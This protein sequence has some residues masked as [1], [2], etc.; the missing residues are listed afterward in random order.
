MD[1]V[2]FWYANVNFQAGSEFNIYEFVS[3]FVCLLR[4]L[5]GAPIVTFF[6]LRY[7]PFDESNLYETEGAGI[8][9]T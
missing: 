7:L 2:N 8:L 4:G 5:R 9:V 1:F 6:K 3:L